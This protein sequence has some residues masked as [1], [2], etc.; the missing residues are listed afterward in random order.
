M[1]CSYTL[2]HLPTATDQWSKNFRVSHVAYR[3]KIAML[4]FGG[5]AI[6]TIGETAPMGLQA[7]ARCVTATLIRLPV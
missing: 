4:F 7:M 5:L 3:K 1:R 6:E 2:P